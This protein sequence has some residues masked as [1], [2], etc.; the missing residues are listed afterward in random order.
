MQDSFKSVDDYI[1]QL[2]TDRQ[3]P[4][5]KLR[6]IILENLPPGFKEE[7]SYG[8]IGY[9]IPHNIYPA[10]YHTDPSLPLPFINLAS[11]KN[12]ISLY[13]YGI[14]AIPELLVWFENEYPKHVNTKLN[15]GKSCIRFKNIKTI[16]YSLIGDLCQKISVED[17]IQKYEER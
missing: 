11:Q 17:F 14:Y 2:P 15:M 4:I 5:R 6:K 7:I 1:N 16:P 13:H 8:M 10:G 3:E 12:Y 9:V